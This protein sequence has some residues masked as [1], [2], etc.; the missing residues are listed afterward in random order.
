MAPI[1]AFAPAKINLT[2][3][4][5]GRRQDGY[6]LL[7]SLVAFADVGDR[8]RV[9]PALELSLEVGG[10]RALGVPTGPDNLVL[11]A[12]ALFGVDEGARITLEKHLPAAAGI[13][14]GS[15]DAAATLRALSKLWGRTIPSDC[16]RLGA[17]IPVCLPSR[18]ARMQGIG[19]TV[20]PLP[21]PP[22][23]AVLVNPG[24]SVPTGPV[25]AA[26]EGQFGAPMQGVLPQFD[27]AGALLDWLGD[28][29]NDLETPARQ[30]APAIGDTLAALAAT[31]HCALAR[32]SGSGA[33]C[34]GLF[35][36][37]ASARAAAQQLSQ[38]HPGWWV[39]ATRIGGD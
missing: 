10:P 14:G 21:L 32:M 1:D 28:Q 11:K 7:D 29:R 24:V 15:A 27:G 20:T 34:F 26:L 38:A 6:H 22:L 31:R 18:T 36:S 37:P 13:G 2:L 19:E 23:D 39:Q 25:F 8:V 30:I 12:A 33:T 17:D 16:A 35:P 5:T 3:H 4:V 9:E